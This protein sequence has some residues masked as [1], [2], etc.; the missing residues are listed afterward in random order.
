M[1]KGKKKN[2]K[3]L[4]IILIIFLV[5]FISLFR[6]KNINI[7]G[8]NRYRTDEIKNFIV[9]KWFKDNILYLRLENILK[10]DYSIP[11][12]ERI[13][14]KMNIPSGI[15]IDVKEKEIS[16]QVEMNGGYYDIS[17]KFTIEGLSE[18]R[19]ESKLLIKNIESKKLDIGQKVLLPSES[20]YSVIDI[21]DKFITKN[22]LN[23]FTEI[24]IDNEKFKLSGKNIKVSFGKNE[25]MDKKLKVLLNIYP[26]I[27]GMK[28]TLYL[29]E[30]K[31][32]DSGYQ[33][34]KD[35]E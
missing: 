12:I 20:D 33:F 18:G 6:V 34:K 35:I 15:T 16:Y 2:K 31:T 1:K 14:I 30:C 9:N 19:S 11:Y 24:S 5:V 7:N 21:I 17:D 26:K 23:E 32:D 25:D 22:E 3:I 8:S 13:D 10:K 27:L 4:I 28:G 29:E